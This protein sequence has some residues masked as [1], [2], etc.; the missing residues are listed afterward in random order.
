MPLTVTRR[1]SSGALTITG[2]V[3]GTRIR[4]RA[5]SD[6]PKLAA[7]EAATIEADLLRAAWH[8]ERRGA[9]SFAEAVTS[10]LEAAPRT[11]STRARVRRLLLALGTA[12][13]AE[14]DQ[15]TIAR[16]KPAVLRPG[17]SPAT[18]SRGV[19]VPLRA[20]LRHAHRRGWCDAPVFEIPR[21]PD[22]RTRCLLPC[23]AERLIAVG[24]PHVRPLLVFLLSTGA[25][26]SEAIELDWRDL[27]LRGGRAI[28]WRTKTGKR[29][30]AMLPPRAVEPWPRCNIGRVPSFVG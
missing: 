29:R 10:Y 12:R 17:A 16:L 20:V 2:T 25:R 15:G 14:I 6:D 18:V 30:I 11:E 4:R 9:R 5:Q 28:F 3:A 26:M 21:G 1:K 8:G 13:L 7:E 23:E 27:D 24:A 22:G 19:I